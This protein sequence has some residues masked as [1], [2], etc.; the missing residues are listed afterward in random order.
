MASL[1]SSGPLAF[2]LEIDKLKE[3]WR[4][5]G[6]HGASR[7]ENSAEHS[8][9]A[10]LAALALAP[11]MPAGVDATRV[12]MLMLAHDLGEIDTGDQL[13]YGKDEEKAAREEGACV[14]RVAALLP[15]NE[16]DG[17]RLLWHE[18]EEGNTPEAKVAR[19]IDRLLPCLEN[20]AAGGGAW[21][22][23]G[24]RLEQSLERNSA[25]GAV[26]P[27]LWNEIR[28]ILVETF[29]RNAASEARES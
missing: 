12:A 24:V 4:K 18:F 23:H 16:G 3:V 10:A 14:D 8:W 5:N 6:V 27:E 9:H 20:I 22:A 21:K 2:L 13:A 29:R 11:R 7:C 19:A 17:I 26:F 25:I 28:P 15:G 1:P